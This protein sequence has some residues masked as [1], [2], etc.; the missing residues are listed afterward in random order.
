MTTARSTAP[1]T[2]TTVEP[3]LA[4]PTEGRG[5]A[6]FDLPVLA[7]LPEL[8]TALQAL[9]AADRAI[10]TAVDQLVHLRR[11]GLIEAAT[12]VG[13]DGWLSIVAR[14]TGS[15]RRM[16]LT[17]AETL[18]R[19]PHLHRCFAAGELSWAQLRTVVLQVH[20]L[21]D[22]DDDE[23]DSALAGAVADAAELEPDALA[24]LVRWIVADLAQEHS[25]AIAPV[26]ERLVLQPRLDGSGGAVVGELGPVGFAALDGAT[27][28]GPDAVEPACA[29]AAR[30]T[31]LCLHADAGHGDGDGTR[32][33]SRAR[34]HVLLRAE[35]DTLLGLDEGPAQ[36]LTGLA[37]GAMWTDAVT[38]R[39]LASVASSVRL[40]VTRDGAPVGIGRRSRDVTDWLRDAV[41]AVHDTCTA[42]GCLRPA[43]T[44][45]VD[46]ATEWTAGGTTDVGNL[47]PLCAHHNRAATRR[48]WRVRQRADGSRRWQHPAT[49]LATTTR[50]D[51]PPAHRDRPRRRPATTTE[52]A[53]GPPA[54]PHPAGPDATRWPPERTR[55]G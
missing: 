12:G 1:P 28:P 26:D 42:P 40:I 14:R 43:L 21:R 3:C 31:D 49:G 2:T 35:I 36:L 46:H 39:E 18:L 52:P 50:P 34:V 41:L 16:L 54:P 38:A 8:A 11:S 6:P 5:E 15:D 23:L 32:G 53:T 37:G 17:V 45:D 20:R 10:A 29:R 25:P 4:A 48:A 33:T 55:P 24:S 51:R 44:A 19:L 9:V 47:G 30:L 22:V 7:E 27:R 13:L